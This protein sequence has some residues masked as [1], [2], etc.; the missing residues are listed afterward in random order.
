[1]HPI[2][3]SID[4]L[5]LWGLAPAAG[6]YVEVSLLLSSRLVIA[7]HTHHPSSHAPLS[8]R[9][10]TPLQRPP[11]PPNIYT[12]TATRRMSLAIA[13]KRAARPAAA[14]GAC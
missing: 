13:L 1:M 10:K 12:P 2:E 4:R 8:S 3:R 9:L 7:H 5:C 11:S 14:A 6:R